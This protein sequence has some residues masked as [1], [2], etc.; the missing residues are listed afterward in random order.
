METKEDFVYSLE[1]DLLE[2]YFKFI[3]RKFKVKKQTLDSLNT[4]FSLC[5]VLQ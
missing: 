1:F 2:E 3:P 4:D 5:I